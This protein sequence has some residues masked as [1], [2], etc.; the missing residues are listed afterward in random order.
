MTRNKFK[1]LEIIY[2]GEHK[3]YLYGAIR[4]I[5]GSLN[6][7]RWESPFVISK[8]NS[9]GEEIVY[10]TVKRTLEKI[11]SQ[12]NRLRRFTAEAKVK[13]DAEGITPIIGDGL[14]LPESQLTQKILDEQED[15]IE[16]ILLTISVNIRILS[17]IFPQKLKKNR[18]KVYN[19]HD[20]CVSSIELREIA[21][22]LLHNRYILVKDQYVID[23]F[24]DEKFMT[25]SPQTG[26]KIN[27]QEYLSEVKKV[28]N[29]TTVDDLISKLCELTKNLSTSSNIRDIIFLTQNLYTMEGLVIGEAATINSGPLNTILNRVTDK[30]IQEMYSLKSTSKETQISTNVVF[31][32]P[33]FTLEP[34][35]NQKEIRIS[36]QVNGNNESLVMNYEKFFSEVSKASGQRKLYEYTDR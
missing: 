6:K 15:I 10:G 25:E 23:L 27:F 13:L 1:K 5:D 18:V 32:S 17:E 35:L 36:M 28:V 2:N 11:S 31:S 26:L 16:D 19:Y 24:S 34:D 33:R 9:K 7:G 8:R 12:I 22:L 20:K 3:P 4:V 21:N 29:G 14:T 30:R